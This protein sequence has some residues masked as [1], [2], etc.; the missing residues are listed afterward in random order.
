MIQDIGHTHFL[1][2]GVSSASPEL[3]P[4]VWV[5]VKLLRLFCQLGD[6]QRPPGVLVAVLH[7]R[8]RF[9]L[10]SVG[11]RGNGKLEGVDV[12]NAGRVDNRVRGCYRR[13][14]RLRRDPEVIAARNVYWR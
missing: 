2:D 7:V 1:V 9:L 10:T 11:R 5:P 6:A 14:T 8:Y 3:E 4:N 13:K 12:G